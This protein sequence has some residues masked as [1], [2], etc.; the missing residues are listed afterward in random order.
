MPLDGGSVLAQLYQAQAEVNASKAK[1]RAGKVKAL[2]ASAALFN[3]LQQN[4]INSMEQLYEKVEAMNSN[5][6]DLR[7]QIVSAER[8]ISVL[9]ERL[10]M[11]EQYQQTKGVRQRLDKLK[12]SKREQYQQEHETELASFDAAV[13]FLDNLKASG[14]TITPKAWQTEVDRLTARKDLE[15]QKMRAMRDDL[16]AVERLKKTAEQLARDDQHQQAEHDR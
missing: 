3:F 6:Y 11:W 12:P 9:S 13:R 8:R 15:Y 1:T 5:Y 10:K 16:K 7:G 4:G 14:E 2:K